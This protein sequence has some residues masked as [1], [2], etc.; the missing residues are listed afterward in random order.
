VSRESHPL[1]RS[2]LFADDV[3]LEAALDTGADAL[4]IDLEEP[5]FP[6]SEGE[7]ERLRAE[8]RSFLLSLP[9]EPGTPLPFVRVQAFDTGQT[10]KD[11]RAVMAPSLA[12]VILPKLYGPREIHAL[13]AVLACLEAEL[14]LERG[15]TLIW[16]ILETAESIRLT[17]EIAAA[18]PRVDYLGPIVDGPHGDTINAV[19]FRPTEGGEELV[20]FLEKVNLDARAAGARRPL[21]VTLA[22]SSS[23]QEVR[24]R[25]MLRVR[26]LGYTGTYVTYVEDIPLINEIFSP[27][28]DEIEEWQSLLRRAEECER[29]GRALTITSPEGN[30]RPA[31]PFTVD[32]ARDGL[33]RARLLGLIRE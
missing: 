17:F 12:G 30:E 6:L 10:L 21:A 2:V 26:D 19:G 32:A 18:S 20:Y 33:E 22:Q 15:S 5:S 16:P 13:D 1:I 4:F 7:R 3:G 14:D 27:T 23:D 29:S 9:R 8:V 28:P 25:A 31:H 24:R 11:L